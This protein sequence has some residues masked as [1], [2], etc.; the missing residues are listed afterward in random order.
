MAVTRRKTW[1]LMG[2][3]NGEGFAGSSPLYKEN[4]HLGLY[5]PV[6][7]ASS[8]SLA[9]LRVHP[10]L[11]MFALPIPFPLPS[12]SPPPAYAIANG[13]GSWLDMTL[14]WATSPA[15]DRHPYPSP[16][17]YPTGRSIPISPADY[18]ADGQGKI[19]YD[20]GGGALC[21]VEL[22][23]AWHLSQYWGEEVYGVKQSIPSTTFL[24][25]DQGSLAFSAYAW[26]DPATEFDWDPSTGRLWAEMLRKMEAAAAALPDG[27]KMDV[28]LSVFWFGDNDSKLGA[29]RC[30]S[31]KQAYKNAIAKW[32]RALVANDWTTLPESQI[33]VVGMSIHP[34]YDTSPTTTGMPAA[35]NQALQEL[36]DEDPFF[37]VVSTA[38][39]ETLAPIDSSHL[40][41]TGY[42][43]AGADIAES[44]AIMDGLRLSQ[45]D[46]TDLVTVDEVRRRVRLFYENNSVRTGATSDA[47]LLAHINGAL[48]H[49][50][51]KLGDQTFWLRR[52]EPMALTG[53]TNSVQS[54]PL[55]VARV[56]R[57]ENPNDSQQWLK[58]RMVGHGSGGKLQIVLL[59]RANGTY[60]VHYIERLK[61]LTVDDQLVPIPRE[62]LEWLVTET[63]YRVARG[64]NN[65]ALRAEL[66]QDSLM[67]H[68]DVS[69]YAAAM[70]RAR[71]DRLTPTRNL[72]GRLTYRGPGTFWR[73]LWR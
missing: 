9:Y 21:G 20:S 36:A 5:G 39:Y 41:H 19:P 1:T 10:G 23:L 62:V 48:F 43:Q 3:S 40:N 26:W 72:G 63:C 49:I 45:M 32:R 70:T 18:R 59:E 37:R 57:I 67:L 8:S 33:P 6:G 14:D 61:E 13:V 24:R 44:L 4:P 64:T 27:E 53:L 7:G 42:V 30:V 73:P 16:Y 65:V 55:H 31:F 25:Y 50:T 58:Y 56:L 68:Q 46:Q 38:D 60:V 52:R 71:M 47:T 34:Y 22:P 17:R 29:D 2:H 15:D 66:K 28:R 11:K 35:L 12:G 69:R 51:N 54:L